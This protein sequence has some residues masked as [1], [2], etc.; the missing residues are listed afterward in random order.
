VGRINAFEV[1]HPYSAWLQA[2]HVPVID[3]CV[4]TPTQGIGKALNHLMG[5]T[6]ILGGGWHE[7]SS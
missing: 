5:D 6:E 4:K 7:L 2:D 3:R 1:I